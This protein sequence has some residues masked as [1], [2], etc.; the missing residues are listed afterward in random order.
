MNQEEVAIDRCEQVLVVV[1]PLK[2]GGADAPV[3]PAEGLCTG[4]MLLM[5]ERR[6]SEPFL[7][8]AVDGIV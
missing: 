5:R 2:T 3:L 4:A 6:D 8:V 7:A 1:G